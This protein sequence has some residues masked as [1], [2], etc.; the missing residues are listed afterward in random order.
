MSITDS[1]PSTQ[2]FVSIPSNS[3]TTMAMSEMMV[4]SPDQPSM[5]SS[6]ISTSTSFAQSNE[7]QVL[8]N[9]MSNTNQ[10]E[11]TMMPLSVT[12]SSTFQLASPRLTNRLIS[13]SSSSIQPQVTSTD[14]QQMLLNF[15]SAANIVIE[16]QPQPMDEDII[17]QTPQNLQKD[18]SDFQIISSIESTTSLEE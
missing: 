9:S 7:T 14:V 18:H 4:T 6:D 16:E 3:N 5:Q 10:S 15:T 1:I 2:G 17:D 11:P 8:M 13:T 12:T